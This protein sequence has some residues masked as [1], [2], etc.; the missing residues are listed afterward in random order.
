MNYAT[1]AALRKLSPRKKSKPR[2]NVESRAKPEN[3]D[4]GGAAERN[5]GLGEGTQRAWLKSQLAVQDDRC[6]DKACFAEP[7]LD[8]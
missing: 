3:C 5:V 4:T 8:K 1:Q 2:P 7:C 6:K